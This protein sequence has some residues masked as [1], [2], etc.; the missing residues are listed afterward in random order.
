MRKENL[1]YPIYDLTCSGITEKWK[2]ATP[3]QYRI[4]NPVMDNHFGLITIDWS[5]PVPII[6]FQVWDVNNRLRLEKIIT[7]R[8][9][10][11]Y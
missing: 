6:K 5:V 8:E 11:S 4:G 1:N 3:N 7:L 9:L 10:Q 2:F